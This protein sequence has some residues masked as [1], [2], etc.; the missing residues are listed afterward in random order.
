V[1]KQQILA[2]LDSNSI[3][4]PQKLAIGHDFFNCED[5]PETLQV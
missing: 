4:R 3:A 2:Q 1:D 5:M